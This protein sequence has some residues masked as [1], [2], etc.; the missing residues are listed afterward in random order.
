MDSYK[1]RPA[2][3]LSAGLNDDSVVRMLLRDSD[4]LPV[5]RRVSYRASNIS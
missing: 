2:Q 4:E 3:A 1:G 5:K